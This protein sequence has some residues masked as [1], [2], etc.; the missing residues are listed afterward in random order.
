MQI[1]RP[2]FAGVVGTTS[3][4]FVLVQLDVTIV[5]VALPNIGAQL[6]A[7]VSALQWVV[8]AYTLAFSVLM[9]TAGSLGD[10]YGSRRWFLIGVSVFAAGSLA[11]ALAPGAAA[12]IAARPLQGIGA[13][14]MLPNLLALLNHVYAD[15]SDT[16][17]RAGLVAYSQPAGP[18]RKSSQTVHQWRAG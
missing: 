16:R 12:L 15:D 9:L 11:C 2:S 17:A 8:D 3:L 1:K 6:H 13:A 14:A 4:A 7:S 5:N 18:G 10:R